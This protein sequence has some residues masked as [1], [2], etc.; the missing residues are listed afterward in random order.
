LA[1]PLRNAED[2]TLDDWRS[3]LSGKAAIWPIRQWSQHVLEIEALL[4][5]AIQALA[6]LLPQ[7]QIDNGV[8]VGVLDGSAFDSARLCKRCA[9]WEVSSVG[10][11]DKAGVGLDSFGVAPHQRPPPI[12][13]E[14]KLSV[15]S[16][17]RIACLHHHTNSTIDQ[18]DFENDR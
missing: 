18:H 2:A 13:R 14:H 11:V 3:Q 9:I 16:A 10:V 4:W 12:C 6:A 15:T 1:R 5:R 17:E 8:G 7:Q